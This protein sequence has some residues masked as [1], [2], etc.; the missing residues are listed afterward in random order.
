MAKAD[1]SF[2]NAVD[3]WSLQ[4]RSDCVDF[5]T[6][7]ESRSRKSPAGRSSAASGKLA[8]ACPDEGVRAYVDSNWASSKS[9]DESTEDGCPYVS[10]A[11]KIR[12]TAYLG[13]ISPPATKQPAQ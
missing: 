3:R 2:S 5:L 7:L 8:L 6:M 12:P 10:L 13:G 11:G 4:L 9:N 1:A